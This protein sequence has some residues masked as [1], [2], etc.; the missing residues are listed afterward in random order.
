MEKNLEVYKKYSN[1]PSWAKKEIIGGRI[2]GM[3][4]INPQWRIECLTEQFGMI[5]IGWYYITTRKWI[6]E[7]GKSEKSAFVD[8]DLF[9][10][11]DGEWSK[12]IQG[13]GG[14]SFIAQEK[15]GAYTSDECFKMATTDA[16][17][18]ACKMLGIGSA[19]Y[20]G[21]KY[22]T[23]EIKKET[24]LPEL[25]PEMPAWDKAKEYLKSGKG[26]IDDV[27]K[28]YDLSVENIALL[29]EQSKE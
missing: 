13:T 6:E 27:K 25:K 15:N 2:K 11:V 4:D 7:G 26:T 5:G 10:K 23:Q 22:P 9:V 21:S 17:S 8:I 19:I 3:T 28:K 14:S 24:S 1:P 12:P 18:V 16:L 20:S 29:T